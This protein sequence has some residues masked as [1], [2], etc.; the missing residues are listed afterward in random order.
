MGTRSLTHVIQ[1]ESYKDK[2]GNL[3]QRTTKIITMYRQF[4]GYPTGHG[5]ELAEFLAS[6]KLVNGIGGDKEK[7]FNGVGCLAAQMVSHF[8]GDTAG[9]IYLYKPGTK[10][11][12]QDYDY[13][14]I[15]DEGENFNYTPESIIIICKSHGKLKFKGTPQAFLQWIKTP[16]G[17][18]A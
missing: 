15:V 14:V 9:N 13:D 6:G 11:A 17:S 5:Q 10:D 18:E 12:W 16:V 2:D 3:K 7:V 1:K 8:K 4:D